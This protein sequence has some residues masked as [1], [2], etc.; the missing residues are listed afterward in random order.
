MS[1][2]K[3]RIAGVPEHF[4]L[5]WHLGIEEGHFE[6]VDAEAEFQVF[7]GGTG[8]M[9]SAVANDEVDLAIVLA[10]GCIQSITSG[11]P[12]K[13]VKT[14]VASPL[15]WGI[16]TPAASDIQSI[17]EMRGKRYA[18]SRFGSGSHLMAVVDADL[19]GWSTEDPSFVVVKNLDGAREALATNEA[20]IFFWEKYTTNPF[21]DNGEFRRIGDRLTPWP[22]FVVCASDKAIA[23]RGDA[24]ARL[25]NQ[26]NKLCRQLTGSPES[27]INQISRR[28][29][30]PV[31]QTTEWFET[32]QWSVDWQM[33]DAKFTS[34]IDYLQSLKLIEG[35]QATNIPSQVWEDVYLKLR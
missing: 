25:L 3:I 32:L 27:T 13:I 28:Y 20:D 10:E 14:F 24:I 6:R 26:I 29:R 31:D 11:T 9:M 8:A 30:L 5:P 22:A 7:S 34:A 17:E 18:I 12:A 19:R 33:D 1:D 16:H 21:V 2:P 23:H 4:N 15:I 35:P